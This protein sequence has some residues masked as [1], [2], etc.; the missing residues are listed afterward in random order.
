MVSF[1]VSW[2]A[3]WSISAS[4]PC[5]ISPSVATR[6]R[7]S[8]ATGSSPTGGAQAVQVLLSLALSRRKCPSTGITSPTAPHTQGSRAMVSFRS[9]IPSLSP[10]STESGQAHGGA[11]NCQIMELSRSLVL[12]GH[13]APCRG[14]LSRGSPNWATGLWHHPFQDLRPCGFPVRILAVDTCGRSTPD[15]PLL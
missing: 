15:G 1:R 3:S 14:R 2:R 6:S 8:I 13:S 10:V 4:K 12:S 9:P 11:A 5:F 7:S